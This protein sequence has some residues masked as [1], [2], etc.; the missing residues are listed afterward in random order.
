MKEQ[1]DVWN[2]PYFLFV[3][4]TNLSYRENLTIF[5]VSINTYYVLQFILTLNYNAT[6]RNKVNMF[7]DRM[8]L[9]KFIARLR[10]GFTGS[11]MS[12][13][14]DAID[15]NVCIYKLAEVDELDEFL[16]FCPDL[17]KLVWCFLTNIAEVRGLEALVDDPDEAT[18]IIDV[19]YVIRACIDKSEAFQ[20]ESPSKKYLEIANFLDIIPYGILTIRPISRAYLYALPDGSLT[21][22]NTKESPVSNKRSRSRMIESSPIVGSKV[23]ARVKVARHR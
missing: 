21:V 22:R 2:K 15:N 17:K 3:G 10:K 7:T 19:L 11:M 13:L 4:M 1:E 18:L 20:P 12:A 8:Y 16:N 9:L 14:T 23:V 5:K 6:H